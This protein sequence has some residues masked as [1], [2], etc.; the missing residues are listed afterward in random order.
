ML[1]WRVTVAYHATE[2]AS[3]SRFPEADELLIIPRL[4]FE[5]VDVKGKF[6]VV[7]SHN[8]DLDREA[9]RKMLTPEVAYLGLVG[10]KYRLEKILEHMGSG[11]NSRKR[12]MKQTKALAKP[13]S[14]GRNRGRSKGRTR[15]RSKGRTRELD[16]ELDRGRTKGRNRGRSKELNREQSRERSR[17][18]RTAAA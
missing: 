4:A 3:G 9:V 12:P 7:M 14:R 16:R 2:K 15:R 6:V 10:S 5:Q 11:R 13:G 18:K 1:Q 17:A 8:L